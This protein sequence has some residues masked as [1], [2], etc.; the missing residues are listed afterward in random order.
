MK[1][2]IILTSVFLTLLVTAPVFAQE[3]NESGFFSR[4][5]YIARTGYSIGGTATLGMPDTIR[6]IDSYKLTPSFSFGGDLRIELLNNWGIMTGLRIENKAMKADITTKNYRMEMV[7]GDSK[8]SGVFTGHVSQEVTE[9]MFTVPVEAMYTIKE[10]LVVRAG[11][12][13]SLLFYKDFSGIASDGYLRAG[14]PVGP[15][16]IIGNK[17]GEW[18]TYDFSDEMRIFQMGINLG[19]DGEVTHHAG[20]SADLNWGLTG[21]FKSDFK[22]VEQTLYPIYGTISVFYKF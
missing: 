21:I 2:N 20:I 12:Y 14:S 18:A 22:T 13:F 19:F 9:W 6:S 7:K 4:L 3:Q 17:E 10:K 11:P 5:S 8:L 1:K 15:K 16:I